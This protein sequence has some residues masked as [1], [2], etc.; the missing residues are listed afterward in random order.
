[1]MKPKFQQLLK[2]LH[3]NPKHIFLIDGLGALISAFSLGIVLVI[4][5]N[6]FGMPQNVLH[7]LA[8]IACIFAIY[9]FSCALR[10]PKIWQLFLKLIAMAN[11][12]YCCVTIALLYYFYQK[13]T[14]LGLIY[15]VLEII[16]IFVLVKI[17][18]AIA[19]LK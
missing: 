17:E 11:F 15:F 9:S 14:I 4:F 7:V 6:Y 5:K 3:S 19:N 18:F 10:M 2:K 16:V 8:A 13:L 12:I 1:M